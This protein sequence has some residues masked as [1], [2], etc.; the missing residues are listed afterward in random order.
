MNKEIRFRKVETNI[1]N[2]V[3]VFKISDVNVNENNKRIRVT[4]NVVLEDLKVY[5]IDGN[6]TSVLSLSDDSGKISGLL[7]GNEHSKIH[8]LL[9]TLVVGKRYH[10][11][12]VGCFFDKATLKEDDD[13]FEEDDFPFVNDIS[14]NRFLAIRA[15]EL[16]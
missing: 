12:G 16:I 2:D 15:I 1:P 11:S 3:T 8:N 5:N 10:I 7:V 13:E 6:V 9:E 4:V 14:G